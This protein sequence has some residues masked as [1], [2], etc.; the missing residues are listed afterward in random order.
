MKTKT[1]LAIAFAANAA[2]TGISNAQDNN[3][4][5]W[6]GA[7]RTGVSQEKGLLQEWPEGGPKKLWS[8]EDAGMGY[9]SFSV[10]DGRLFTIGAR[11]GVETLI[12]VDA[13]TGKEIWTTEFSGLFRNKWGDGPRSCPTV[14]GAHV[15]AMGGKGDLVCANVSDGKVIWKKSMTDDFGGKVPGW[16]YTESPLVDGD[17]VICT[18]G[19]KGGALVALNAKDGSTIWQSKEFTDGA[20]YSSAIAIEHDGKRQYVQL[21]MKNL[22]GIDAETGALLWKS[23]WPGKTAVI[24]TPIYHDGHVYIASGY[25]VGCKL[26]K[27]GAGNKVEDVYVNTLMI[28]HHGGVILLDGHLYGY[29]DKNGWVCQDFK[30]GEQVWAEKR[31]LRKGAIAYADGHFYCQGEGDGSIVLIEASSEGWKEKG[32]FVLDPQTEQRADAG[33]IWTHPVICDGKLYLRDQ[34]LIHCYD[35]EAK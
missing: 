18:P 5:G 2:L 23:A 25:G 21:V 3:W 1:F 20:Q 16:G 11:D 32:R 29:S 35:I 15:Y 10:V 13:K 4:P 8:Y 22:V 33:K 7:D 9:S 27:L 14:S 28:N 19:G 34:E 12:C 17:K 26:V 31:A 6:R 24:P 30:S